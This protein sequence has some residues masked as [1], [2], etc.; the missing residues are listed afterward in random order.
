MKTFALPKAM[1]EDE[2]T[3]ACWEKTFAN[4]TSDKGLI[5]KI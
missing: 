5:T 4:Y 2:K 1:S 3:A